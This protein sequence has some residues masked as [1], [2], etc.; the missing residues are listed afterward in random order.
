MSLVIGLYVYLLSFLDQLSQRVLVLQLVNLLILNQ[1]ALVPAQA[2]HFQ[3]FIFVLHEIAQIFKGDIFG[4]SQLDLVH[5]L[6]IP[7][8]KHHFQWLRSRLLLQ[9]EKI[10]RERLAELQLFR[11][12]LKVVRLYFFHLRPV[13]VQFAFEF[14]RSVELQFGLLIRNVV[15]L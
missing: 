1:K 13:P 8:L 11:A 3:Q 7:Y 5:K 10:Q 14:Q 4:T 15:Q 6:V 12:Y 2:L 9:A